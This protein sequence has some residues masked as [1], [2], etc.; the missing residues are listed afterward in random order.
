MEEMNKLISRLEDEAITKIY[1]Q[2]YGDDELNGMVKQL[3]EEL[4]DISAIHEE[5]E[6]LKFIN[7]IATFS[8]LFTTFSHE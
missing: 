6:K 4:Y 2:A 3:A 1:D 7:P 8:K 5:N